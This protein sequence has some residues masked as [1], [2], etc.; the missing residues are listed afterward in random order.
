MSD[1]PQYTDEWESRHWR[2]DRAVEMFI[3]ARESG[4]SLDEPYMKL[5]EAYE[6]YES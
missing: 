5:K 1:E 4:R 2:L 6:E 3:E